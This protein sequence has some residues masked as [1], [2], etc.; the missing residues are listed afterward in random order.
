MSNHYLT[1]SLRR[2]LEKTVKEARIVAEDGARDGIRRLGVADGKAPSYLNDDE[3]ELRRR[4]RAH[5][6]AMG[7]I[8]DKSDDTQETR[9]LVEAAGYAH[10]HRMLF[11][12]FL[13]ERGLLR[14]P[15]YDVPVSLEDCRELAEAEGLTDPWAIAERYAAAMLPAV[16]RI[17]DPVLALQLD[18]VHTQKLHQLVTALDTEVFQA[19]DSL[20]WTYQFW[21]AAEK[22]AVNT[23]GVKIGADEL[24]AVTQLFTEPYMVRFLLHNTLGAWWAGKVLA[25]NPT[26]AEKA[27]DENALRAACSLP[28]YNFDM[29]RFVRETKDGPWLPAAGTFSG[30][31]DEAKAITMLDPCCGSGH[32]L[33]EALSIL[34]ALRQAEERV[35]AA[36]AVSAALKDNLYGLEIDGRCVQIA[37]FAVALTAWRIGGWQSLPLPH[38]AWVGAPPPLPER[39]F[40]ALGEGD[41][42]LEY[43]LAALY[44]L[45]VQAPSLG[46][47]IEPSGGD[48]F[49]AEK[50]GEIE[51][52]LGPL[53]EKAREA[54]PEKSEGVIAAR[55]MADAAGLLH[56]RYVLQLTNVPYLGRG[57]QAPVLSAHIER[58]FENAKADLATAM[59]AR[60]KELAENGGTISALTP[61]NWI[62]LGVYKKFRQSIL[63]NMAINA[64]GILG[65]GAFETISGEV[66]NVLLFTASNKLPSDTACYSGFDASSAPSAKAKEKF[67]IDCDLK[68]LSQKKTWEAPDQ[69]IGVLEI[70]TNDLLEKH[71]RSFK[72]LTVGDI[73]KSLRRF[74]EIQDFNDWALFQETA[75][76]TALYGGMS[77]ALHFGRD[78]EK[79]LCNP[80]A[81]MKGKE[82]WGQLGVRVNQMGDLGAC[83]YEGTPFSESAATIIPHSDEHR[84]AIWAYVSSDEYCKRVREIDRAL[85]V[86]N[87]TLAKV[88]FDLEYWT[89]IAKQEYPQGL[90]E[91]YSDD[92]TQWLFHGHPAKVTAGLAVHV[93]LA[94]LCGYRWP[95]ESDVDMRL[96]NEAKGWLARSEKL[97]K[98]DNDGLLGVPA[99]ASEKPLAGRLRTYLATAF[100][101]NWSDALER[102]LVAEADET[103][104]KKAFKDD[105]LEA[106]LSDRAF[107]QHCTLFGQRPFLWHITD[108]LKDGFSVFVHYH[109]FDQAALRKLTYTLLGDWL[110]RAKAEGNTLRYEKGRELQ[111]VLEK[112]LEGEKPYDIF[113]RWK[114][115]AQQPL[116]WDPDLDDGLRQN[117]RPFIKAGVLTHELS[118]I[119]KDKDRGKDVPSA[120]WYPVF[121]GERRNDHHTTLDEKHAAR[122][123]IA[124]PAEAAK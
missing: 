68:I 118:K 3:K 98:G 70:E 81:L 94:R 121:K 82:A 88:P 52:L 77:A 9:R 21:R 56:R 99:V 115:L 5:A 44:D 102:R 42:E 117:I 34:A 123:A 41:P 49:E 6:R 103:L 74:W 32:F 93:A 85:K 113:V 2:T 15:E 112:V 91:P 111:Q 22:D 39:D 116:G 71:A 108:G 78:G 1:T 80:S 17:D 30:W 36:E 8:L 69:R 76:E 38:V 18:P 29:L 16:F 66:V 14:N 62:Y 84:A 72:G 75:N 43:A 53:L 63:K 73:A 4:L 7:D 19:E 64:I 55:G 100:D 107:R 61:Q 83:L 92:P 120:P 50:M 48:L 12:R 97:P 27:A 35:N 37:V 86:T 101:T 57:K 11:A 124:N 28:N 45:F 110:A 25:A 33:T 114:S 58:R 122:E 54:E 46:T 60:M 20:G 79:F 104:D 106:W 10:W 87:L 13:A 47:L 59:L 90:P 109:R 119:L 23:S 51:R 24:P 31:P 96:S 67:I 95:A 65:P 26:L 105:S 89:N 40:V